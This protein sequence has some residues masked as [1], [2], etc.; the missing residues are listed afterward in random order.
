MDQPIQVLVVFANP[1]GTSSL[2]LSEEDRAITESI[3]R[4]KHRDQIKLEKCHAATI[5]DFSRALLDNPFRIVHISGHGTQSGLVLEKED[6]SRNVV[7]QLALSKTCSAYAPPKGSLECVILNSC[8]SVSTGTLIS[9]G[10]PYTIAMEGPISDNAAIEFSRGFYDAIAAG[11]DIEFAYDEGCRRVEL[12]APGSRFVSR[13]LRINEK[14]TLPEVRPGDSPTIT[15]QREKA[16]GIDTPVLVGLGIDLSASMLTSLSNVSGHQV[17][18][19]EG[20]RQ[21]LQRLLT[22]LKTGAEQRPRGDFELFAYGF[23]FRHRQI[24]VADIFSLMKVARSIVTKE[25]IERLQD[26]HSRTV[27]RKYASKAAQYGGLADLA[28]RHGLG[29]LVEN[30]S[31]GIAEEAKREVEQLVLADITDRLAQ[32]LRDLAPA[33][34]TVGEVAEVWHTSES[35]FKNAS[36]LLFGN[37]PMRAC[38]EVMAVRFGEELGRRPK[39]TD[40]TLFLLS[41]GEPTDGSPESAFK[42]IHEQGVTV[43]SCFVTEMDIADPKVL[44]STPDP[45]WT[46]GARLMF[47]A[48][49]QLSNDSDL[50]N[51]LLRKGWTI[52]PAAKLFVQINH[53]SILDEFMEILAVPARKVEKQ[54]QLPIGDERPNP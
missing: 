29:G 6:G 40:A 2:R 22:N 19:L 28:R 49:S 42:Q 54:W 13:I 39:G 14:C 36:E 3:R 47:D 33:T 10:V 11:K 50:G 5:H 41:D 1:R 31:Q 46:R 32:A 44:Y 15:D 12:T 27:K 52:Q 20:V 43:V 38:L 8:Y 26:E 23:G 35:A 16:S 7:P 51:F 45:T 37:T 53:T 18:R 48:A 25:E 21:S 30:V 34:L 24:E 17:T 4:A 9:L